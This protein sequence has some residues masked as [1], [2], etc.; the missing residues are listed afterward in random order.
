[1]F[2]RQTTTWALTLAL[3][4]S[5]LQPRAATESY[6]VDPAKSRVTIDVGKAGA[7]SFVAGH[8]HEVTGPIENGLVDF[9]RDDPSNSRVRLVIDSA[10]LKVT[11][12]GESREDVPKVQQ[13]MES[14]KVLDVAHHPQMLFQSTAITINGRRGDVLDLTIAG[15]LTIRSVTQPVTIP[16]R[17]EL[18]GETIVATG[19]FSITQT[20][21]GIAPIS[22]AGV[23]KVKDAL[24]ISVSIVARR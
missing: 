24:D 18:T 17:A 12:K 7:F 23:V 21:Y 10:T 22:I 3:L 19:R 1:M 16:V 8:T 14:D 15:R 11:G 6:T 5:P 13:A 20:A 4:S 2:E 9:D